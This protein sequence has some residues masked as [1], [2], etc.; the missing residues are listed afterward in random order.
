ML[1]FGYIVVKQK[2]V[3]LAHMEFIVY[4][5]ERHE[6]NW[7]VAA[8]A[9]CEGLFRGGSLSVGHQSCLFSASIN[10]KLITLVRK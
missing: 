6:I 7:S 2:E 3:G 9:A 8:I 4:F 5:G 1:K 10:D